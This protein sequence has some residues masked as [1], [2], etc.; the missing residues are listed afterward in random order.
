[1]SDHENGS[2]VEFQIEGPELTRALVLHPDVRT[3]GPKSGWRD[4]QAKLDEAV[5]LA[6]AIDLDIAAAIIVP[7]S[8]IQPAAYFGTG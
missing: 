4:A 7:L 6:L 3:R 5:G 2:G 8:G 1:M